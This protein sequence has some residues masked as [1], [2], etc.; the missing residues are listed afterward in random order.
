MRAHSENAVADWLRADGPIAS[1][2]TIEIGLTSFDP[3]DLTLRAARLLGAADVIVH[4]GSVPGAILD[5]A[6]ADAI[7]LIGEASV[8]T[9]S[10]LVVILRSPQGKPG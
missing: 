9:D 10:Q 6:R 1:G 5:R 4:D 3:D 7:R 8:P 2:Q